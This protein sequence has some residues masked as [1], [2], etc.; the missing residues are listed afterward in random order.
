MERKATIKRDTNETQIEL[1]LCLDG[2]NR[3]DIDTGV[4]FF[5][6]ML[7]LMA[8]HGFMDLSVKCKG[9]LHIDAHHTVEDIGLALGRAIAE[10]VGDKKGIRR[11]ASCFLP[12]DEVLMLVALDLS[13]RPYLRFDVDLP[14]G[15]WVGSM[16]AQLFEEFFR[17]AAVQAGITLHI[18][19]MSGKNIHHIVEAMCK[20][21]GRALADAVQ[22]DAR[23][24]GVPSTKGRL[25]R[26]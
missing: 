24:S 9:D 20:G 3:R 7:D 6:H 19:M 21:F 25:D 10:A 2:Q 17:A 14:A 15:A 1:A 16:D 8:A 12:M 23:V 18:Q 13:G 4:G 22:V 5:D 26:Q 11:Y